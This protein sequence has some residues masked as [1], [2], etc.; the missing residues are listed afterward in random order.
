MNLTFFIC[1]IISLISAAI[2]LYKPLFKD[3]S[4]IYLQKE[5]GEKEFDESL[6]LLEMISELETDYSMGKLTQQDY[7]SLSLEYKRQ[8]LELSKEG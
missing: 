3:P 2:V 4:T 8:Y 7:E 5:S 1:I 6:S